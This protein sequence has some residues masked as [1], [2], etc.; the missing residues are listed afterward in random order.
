[1]SASHLTVIANPAAGHGKSARLA[2]EVHRL[3]EEMGLEHR[4]QISEGPDEPE[5]LAKEAALSGS[6][7]VVALGGDGLAGMVANGLIGTDAAMAVVPG[8]NGNDFSRSLGLDRKRPLD[9]LRLLADPHLIDVDAVLVT[10]SEA[11]RHYVN[12]AGAGFDSEVNETAN[13]MDTRLTGTARYI[14][15]V[16]RTLRSFTPADLEIAVDGQPHSLRAMFVAL[17][18]GRSYGGGMRVCP[19][20]QLSDGAV[21]ICIVGEMGK[22]EFL[23][24]FPK[25]FRGSHTAHPKVTMLRGSSVRVSADRATQVYGDGERIGAL[26]ASFEVVPK[27]LRV[28]VP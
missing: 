3:L 19:G 21:E 15:A 20:A 7:I 13:G 27:A 1:V 5:R 9:A 6:D 8:G 26:P 17:G 23:R 4:I 28:V 25:V 18:N 10:T 12:V 11:T 14:A 22:F 16:F 24:N 2:P